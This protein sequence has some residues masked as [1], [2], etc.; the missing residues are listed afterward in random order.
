[1]DGEAQVA[2]GISQGTMATMS[3]V[4]FKPEPTEPMAIGAIARPRD[5]ELTCD[6][7]FEAKI[8]KGA[9]SI[10]PRLAYLKLLKHG[11]GRLQNVQGNRSLDGVTRRWLPYLMQQTNAA[12]VMTVHAQS[13]NA[14]SGVLGRKCTDTI[15][16]LLAECD[17]TSQ[18]MEAS[19]AQ[20]KGIKDSSKSAFI[21]TDVRFFPFEEVANSPAVSR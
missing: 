16:H 15:Q 1:M 4:S 20:S 10:F 18:Q 3:Q 19:G 7:L 6:Y 21:V 9:Q 12:V 11:H 13:S 2:Q 8:V 17:R 14:S 5:E